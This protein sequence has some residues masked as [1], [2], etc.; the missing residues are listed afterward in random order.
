MAPARRS[1][2]SKAHRSPPASLEDL[3]N[4]GPATLR[5]FEVLG[6]MSVSQL[7][8]RNAIG[9]WKELGRRTGARHDPC[10]IDVFMSAIAQA[11]GA[12]PCPWWHFTTE[13]K[14]M[15]RRE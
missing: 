9:L 2:R 3:A 10:C 7:K 8:S 13:R 14:R 4:V 12:A 5:D 1:P 11:N 15:M 6:I